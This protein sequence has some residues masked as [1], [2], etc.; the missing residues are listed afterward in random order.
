MLRGWFESTFGGGALLAQFVVVT[1]L[2]V[3][4]LAV[5]A[6]LLGRRKSGSVSR[7]PARGRQPRL[8]VMEATIVDSKRR[9]VLV[10]R[11]QIEHLV[12]IGGPTDIVVET[13]IVRGRPAGHGI[14]GRRPSPASR[15]QQ[16]S[17]APAVPG[18]Q[19]PAA[20]AAI[21]SSAAATAAAVLR[22]PGGEAATDPVT[23]LRPGVRN[24]AGPGMAAAALRPASPP[25]PT[26][27]HM[28]SASRRYDSALDVPADGPPPTRG[29]D[30]AGQAA[31]PTAAPATPQ[32][33]AQPGSMAYAGLAAG[34]A[35]LAAA[36]GSKSR[37]HGTETIARAATT[38]PEALAEPPEAVSPAPVQRH[39]EPAPQAPAEDVAAFA[40]VTPA[41]A[42]PEA[43]TPA[44]TEP[45]L[46]AE[47]AV[48]PLDDL[49]SEFEKAFESSLQ[50]LTPA[51]QTETTEPAVE[52]P[53]DV[54][55]EVAEPEAVVAEDMDDVKVTDV[56]S[57]EVIDEPQPMDEPEPVEDVVEPEPVE[58]EPVDEPSEPE[59][60]AAFE[61]PQAE[62][63]ASRQIP[64]VL[65]DD[66]LDSQLYSFQS[67]IELPPAMETAAEEPASSQEDDFD[68]SDDSDEP[69]FESM[70]PMTNDDAGETILD[71]AEPEDDTTPDFEPVS[72]VF[73]DARD[74]QSEPDAEATED[75]AEI[76]LDYLEASLNETRPEKA[77]RADEP[78]DEVTAEFVDVE[79]ESAAEEAYAEAEPAI[80][81]AAELAPEP[82]F[83]TE[84]E[85]ESV[86]ESPVETDHA[87]EVENEL[88]AEIA[89]DAETGAEAEE[90]AEAAAPEGDRSPSGLPAELAFLD[91][92]ATPDVAEEEAE[93]VV[94]EEPAPPK[95]APRSVN[96]FPTIPDNVRKSVME[97]ARRAV[98]PAVAEGIATDANTDVAATTLGDLAQRLEKA[99]SEQAAGKAPTALES[100]EAAAV[101]S[102]PETA[103]AEPDLAEENEPAEESERAVIDFNARRRDEPDPDDALEDEM[104]RLLNDLTGDTNRVG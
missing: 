8:S 70:A 7:G 75:D 3:L 1:I 12:M 23:E 91:Q 98:S 65:A 56:A 80:D 78:A 27:S 17:Q 82:E 25:Q 89:V 47:A 72:D 31:E 102:E 37:Q 24:G 51:N 59:P 81:T 10:R 69:A 85:I 103:D 71:V 6:W 39:V 94:A 35:A 22:R 64:E 32:P 2:L 43:E 19:M 14:P 21:A 16:P 90:P 55:A 52:Q 83:D 34:A 63:E 60:V 87:A 4:V 76:D 84:P 49:E 5:L 104:A 13:N 93:P 99:L 74:R 29:L 11:D 95:P 97:A 79:A 46:A 58:P 92:P 68:D 40:P 100:E 42:E 30:M 44:A 38:E 96:P 26:V 9:L 53:E 50:D 54:E 101:E 15:A 57:H 18:H 66:D 61:D 45:E 33:G 88:E 73:A 62:T 67:V 20:G 77:Q 86:T 36:A 48:D 41:T 28:E